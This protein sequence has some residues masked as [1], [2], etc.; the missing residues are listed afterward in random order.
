MAEEIS[1]SSAVFKLLI[2]GRFSSRVAI[3]VLSFTVKLTRPDADARPRQDFAGDEA[4]TRPRV[5]N[6]LLIILRAKLK[7]FKIILV[8][9]R[10][11]Y[12]MCRWSG[13]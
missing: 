8:I 4:A 7:M 6:V 9:A 2:G 5:N 10:D 12:Q 1:C 11:S 13:I 3:P